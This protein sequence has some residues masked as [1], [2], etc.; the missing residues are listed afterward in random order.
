MPRRWWTAL[1]LVVC[2]TCALPP[3]P[4]SSA[5]TL[6]WPPESERSLAP[7]FVINGLGDTWDAPGNGDT[8]VVPVGSRVRWHLTSGIHTI[9]DGLGLEDPLAGQRFDYLLDNLHPDFDTTFTAPDTVN[10]FCA[11]HDPDMRGV[12]V[13]SANASVPEDPAANVMH[14][15]RLPAPNPTRGTMSCAVLLP[16]ASRVDVDVLDLGGRRIAWVEQA[17]LP[18]GEHTFR[19]DGRTADGARAATGTYLVRVSADNV[20]AARRFTLLR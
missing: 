17:D 9:T 18:A 11:F 13:I 16:A 7:D 14:F 19:W 6:R 20:R 1:L 5:R 12:L 15:T 8:L 4:R 10:Y 2:A 3:V